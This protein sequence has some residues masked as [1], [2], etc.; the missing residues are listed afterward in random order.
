MPQLAR[1]A[2]FCERNPGISCQS[3]AS[4]TAFVGGFVF[5][6][7]S[8]LTDPFSWVPLKTP[9]VAPLKLTLGIVQFSFTNLLEGEVVSV[10]AAAPSSAVR[11][12][13]AVTWI[14]NILAL[15]SSGHLTS[16]RFAVRNRSAAR[17]GRR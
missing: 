8:R 10:F 16:G 13:G 14:S 6:W 11:W 12:L 15:H 5:T 17:A 4:R 3:I 2:F 7:I 1:A 9:I